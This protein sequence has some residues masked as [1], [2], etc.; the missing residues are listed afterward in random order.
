MED[1][2]SSNIQACPTEYMQINGLLSQTFVRRTRYDET[3]GTSP[4][5]PRRQ[6]FCLL[7]NNVR[8]QEVMSLRE[9]WNS[10]ASI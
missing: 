6:V 9:C 5:V 1:L 4:N 2:V 3:S 8:S 7:M 10:H